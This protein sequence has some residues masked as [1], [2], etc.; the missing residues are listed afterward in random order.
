[1]KARTFRLSDE[2]IKLIDK[3]Q[4]ELGG[5]K[6]DAIRF[7]IHAGM[8]AVRNT[9]GVGDSGTDGSAVSEAVSALTAQ[10]GDARRANRDARRGAEGRTANGAG[11]ADASRSGA[12]GN[13]GREEEALAIPMVSWERMIHN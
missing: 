5:S 8:D 6:T 2:D 7:A 3:L 10:L 4:L 9:Q 13:R 1:M 12:G 11:G